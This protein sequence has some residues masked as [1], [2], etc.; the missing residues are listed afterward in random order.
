MIT[1][2]KN[3]YNFYNLS[4]FLCL[5]IW[6][7]SLTVIAQHPSIKFNLNEVPFSFYNAGVSIR[8]NDRGELVVQ[9]VSGNSR[10]GEGVIFSMLKKTNNKF[11]LLSALAKPE[12]VSIN[13]GDTLL[14]ETCFQS[15]KIIRMRGTSPDI[16][17]KVDNGV[18]IDSVFA[19]KIKLHRT[20]RY[21]TSY[22]DI[23]IL[24]G[25]MTL[26]DSIIYFKLNRNGIFD[27]AITSPI[28][29][30]EIVFCPPLKF[31]DCLKHSAETFHNWSNNLLNNKVE[32]DNT[33]VKASYVMWS[34]VLAPAGHLKRST[35]LMSKNTMH[36]VWS[37]DHCFNALACSYNLPELAWDQFITVFDE[38]MP[39]GQ[40]PDMIGRGRMEIEHV[41]PPIHGWML[42][43]MMNNMTLSD[44][45][46][47]EAYDKI[48]LWTNFWLKFRDS[49]NNGIPEYLHG[50]DSGWD[51][52]TEFDVDAKP[53]IK[54]YRE[55]ANLCAFLII[56]MDVLHDIALLLNKSEEAEKWKI[57]SDKLLHLMISNLWVQNRFRT[58]RVD[59]NTWN[60]ESKSLM[61][62]LPIVLGNKL[63]KEITN[64]LVKELSN[65]GYLTP[66]GL[67]TE[68]PNTKLYE[69]DGYWRGPIWAPSTFIIVKGLEG[70]NEDKLAAQI[71]LR[72]CNLCEKHG[73]AENFNAVTGEGLRDKAYTWTASIY[74]L[75]K[76]SFNK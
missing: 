47:L 18:I 64:V 20:Y 71:A 36:F 30:N 65:D 72:F 31:D 60:S 67:A 32:I 53:S 19:N 2:I 12:K 52:G 37:W 58:I 22:F 61:A 24:E 54:L 27:V 13:K 14:L 4:L 75:L 46:L 16:C 44:Y 8:Y 29:E 41:K 49:N 23:S 66:W 43:L 6:V 73:F 28:N 10:M 15:S 40:L 1:R 39:N 57:Q 74:L 62:Y 25:E 26:K 50:N 42:R 55:S 33:A 9:D 45:K 68:I 17:F 21:G 5:V 35:M 69:S 59:N 56:Q 63:P 48:S 51:N 11:E 38:Q 7:Q 70:I 3:M 34:A 76:H